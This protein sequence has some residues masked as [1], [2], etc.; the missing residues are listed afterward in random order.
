VAEYGKDMASTYVLRPRF[1]LGPCF[2]RVGEI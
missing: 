2:G 1:A